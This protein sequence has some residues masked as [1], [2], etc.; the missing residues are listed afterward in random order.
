M[1]FDHQEIL[2]D[3][4]YDLVRDSKNP[5]FPGG[6]G[7][8]ERMM[9]ETLIKNSSKFIENTLINSSQLSNKISIQLLKS[10]EIIKETTE[11]LLDVTPSLE[12]N[13]VVPGYSNVLTESLE[14]LMKEIGRLESIIKDKPKR[15]KASSKSKKNKISLPSDQK[16]LY[17]KAELE[18]LAFSDPVTQL[19]NRRFLESFVRSL[20]SHSVTVSRE[21]EVLSQENPLQNRFY[22]IFIDI[23]DFKQVNDIYGH[24]YGDILLK[25]IAQRLKNNLRGRDIVARYGGDEFVALV[26]HPVSSQQEDIHIEPILTRL[27]GV[28]KEPY[29]IKDKSLVVTLSFGVSEF[30]NHGD[31]IEHL[32]SCADRAMYSSKESGKNACTIYSA[33]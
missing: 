3:S 21:G 31:T 24:E 28:S 32:L 6:L 2:D 8:N 17:Q 25:A 10:L 30:P 5:D 26:H 11:N 1:N 12:E 4:T 22:I 7:E 9:A 20:M 14:S 16:E 19:P 29:K 33:P 27:M 18:Y 23:D 13:L 15:R